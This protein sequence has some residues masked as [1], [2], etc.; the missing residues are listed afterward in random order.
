[1]SGINFKTNGDTTPR[2]KQKIWIAMH[3]SDYSS[4][5]FDM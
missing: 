3:P 4:A 1:M 2:G 5:Q